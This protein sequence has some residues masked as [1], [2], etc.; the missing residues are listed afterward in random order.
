MSNVAFEVVHKVTTTRPSAGRLAPGLSG[1]GAQL[2]GSVAEPVQGGEHAVL[3]HRSRGPERLGKQADPEFFEN[4]PC[5]GQ[6]GA[7]PARAGQ[8]RARL[9][10]RLTNPNR[11][12]T[13]L[14]SSHLCI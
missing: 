8:G 6:A 10:R 3:R 4:P 7:G 11:K 13:R 2:P 1:S 5:L 9:P 14:N 12:N